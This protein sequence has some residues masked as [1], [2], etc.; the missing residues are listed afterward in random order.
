MNPEKPTVEPKE[1]CGC[2]GSQG[3]PNAT[4]VD[5]PA[6]RLFLTKVSLGLS[7]LI[8]LAIAP[9]V[10]AALLE[11]LLDRPPSQWRDVGALSDF[12][13]SETVLVAFDNS[14]TIAWSGKSGRTGAWLRRIDESRFEAFTLNCA[15]LGCPVRWEKQAELF[16]CPCHG[17]VYYKDGSVA[18]GPPPHGLARYQ[19]KVQGERVFVLAEPVPITT[20]KA[21]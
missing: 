11:P 12:E 2:G 14:T 9:P 13:I 6:R 3:A 7:G 21:G 20:M 15:H 4:Q 10:A 5:D 19:V 17:G 18:G 8:G 16:L 1:C